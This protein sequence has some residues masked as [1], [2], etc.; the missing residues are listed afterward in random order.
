MDGREARAR[1][2]AAMGHR[3]TNGAR[4]KKHVTLGEGAMTAHARV[5]PRVWRGRGKGANDVVLWFRWRVD[6]MF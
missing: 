2:A 5:E 1:E 4:R 3:R 6:V